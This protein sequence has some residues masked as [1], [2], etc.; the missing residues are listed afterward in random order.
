MLVDRYYYQQLNKSEQA[1]YKAFYKGVMAH[2][3][4]IPLSIKGKMSD[5]TFNKIYTALTLDNPLIYFVNQSLC[6]YVTDMFGRTAIYPQYFYTYDKVR[7]YNRR[8]EKIISGLSGQLQLTVGSDY[9]KEKKL[10]DWMC[11][12]VEYDFDGSDMSNP[13]RVVAAHNII[14]VLFH[15]KAQCEGIAKAMK[16]ILNAIDVK[17]IVVTGNAGDVKTSGPHAWNIVKID[18]I[19][20]QLDV[21]WDINFR[22]LVPGLISYNYFNV[23]D[24]VM[25]KAHHAATIMPVC[26]EQNY[27]YFVEAGLAFKNKRQL[28]SYFKKSIEYG[29]TDFYFKIVGKSRVTAV[30]NEAANYVSELLAKRGKQRLQ[31][32]MIPVDDIGVCWMKII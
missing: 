2:E 16:V 25:N 6:G 21:T 9:E 23:T 4:I 32:Q 29:N 1:V 27:N 11:R 24:D 15:H 26:T 18:N 8:I 31:V 30:A 28:F 13:G 17:C 20:Y 5:D 14:G 3:D 12:N 10:H 22:S 19:P 7:E